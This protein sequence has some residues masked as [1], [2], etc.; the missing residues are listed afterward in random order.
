MLFSIIVPVYNVEKYLDECLESIVLQIEMFPNAC[1]VIL[2]NDGSTDSSGKICD[3]YKEK[4]PNI[5]KVYHNS[6]Q[7]LL[8]TRRC[9]FKNAIG[10][11][12]VNCDSDDKLENDFL[13]NIQ[14]I[15]KKYQEPDAILFNFY[16]YDGCSK[17]IAFQNIF[18]SDTDCIIEKTEV[19]KEFM[20]GHHIV[21][22]CG[23]ICKRTCI[24]VN[25]DYVK[26]GKISTG[27]DSLQSIE[28]Y[29]NAKTFA[30][31]NKA[32][33]DYRCGSG[34]TR[35]FD[36]SYYFT[37]KS[38]FKQI[39]TQK[40]EWK[41]KNFDELF[42]VKVLQT[43]GRAITQSRYNKWKSIDEQKKYLRKIR[44][45]EV[46]NNYI[47]YLSKVKIELQKNH[48]LLIKLFQ[49]HALTAICLLLKT[50]NIIERIFKF[51]NCNFKN[52]EVS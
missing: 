46:F 32:I 13:K 47:L 49:Y 17:K 23:K 40:K 34:M 24:D 42:A 33:Y 27:E 36:E 29:S 45:D 41:I 14:E 3:K 1:E 7:G 5:I 28:I 30:Y 43:T 18:T 12:I 51:P 44:E 21:S 38:I 6:N 22:M 52:L 8:L 39:E 48:V 4:Y 31:L 9:G 26:F 11:Y 20:L 16:R 2:I 50:K 15:I 37:F 10:D 35:K 25:Y 19:I